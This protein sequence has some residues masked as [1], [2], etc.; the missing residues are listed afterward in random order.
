M[1]RLTFAATLVLA[2][3]LALGFPPPLDPN[4]HLPNYD[5]LHAL[6]GN[7]TAIAQEEKT[8][9]HR[10]LWRANRLLR[11]CA[12]GRAWPEVE[13]ELAGQPFGAYEESDEDDLLYGYH[14]KRHTR[15]AVDLGF[16]SAGG[17]SHRCL[18]SFDTE[19]GDAGVDAVDDA[20][21]ILV[22]KVDLPHSE[23]AQ[24]GLYGPGSIGEIFLG[25]PDARSTAA[26]YPIL[27]SIGFS[28]K[29]TVNGFI[30]RW[31]PTV[32]PG[33]QVH[34]SFEV[35]AGQDHRGGRTIIRAAAS[36]LEP[37]RSWSGKNVEWVVWPR[38]TLGEFKAS[39]WGGCGWG[40]RPGH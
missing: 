13:S 26:D 23:V 8:S 36:G 32:N 3:P 38:E 22:G 25:S 7:L 17:Q 35:D 28:F 29:H 27:K 4:S 11:S 15:E 39:G 16:V 40:W 37:E 2:A 6:H 9:M 31:S 5:S 30:S 21:V 14:E 10:F 33:I 1:R 18:I 24:R 20:F 34:A 12:A 19:S